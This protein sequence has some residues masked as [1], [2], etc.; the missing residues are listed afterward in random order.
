MESYLVSLAFSVALGLLGVSLVV[1]AWTRRKQ[2]LVYESWREERGK[3]VSAIVREQ[4]PVGSGESSGTDVVLQF[5][6]RIGGQLRFGT[7]HAAAFRGGEINAARDFAATFSP[8]DPLTIYCDPN[9]E[10][11]MI[12]KK[13]A[14]PWRRSFAA[15][16]ACIVLAVFF[17]IISQMG[18]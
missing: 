9:D 10:H 17:I 7:V 15:G 14:F 4:P 18:G 8:G 12:L 11:H 1:P 6:F 3:L 16:C 2:G 5:E 13:P